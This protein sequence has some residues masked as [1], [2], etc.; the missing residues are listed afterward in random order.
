MA[1]IALKKVT[2]QYPQLNEKKSFFRRKMAGKHSNA[3]KGIDLEIEDGSFTVIVGPSG[4][5]KSTTLRMIAG[6]EDIT[7]GEIFIGDKKV[8]DVSSGD[9]NIAMVFQN[10][11][12]YPTM[13]VRQNIAFGLENIKMP[14]HEINKR[15]E[16]IS[17]TVGLNDYLDRKPGNLSGG[18]RQRVALARAIVKRPEV[19]IFDEPLS[20]LDAK[21]RAEMRSELIEM[22]KELKTTF[23]YVTHD[24]VEAM[25]MADQIVLMHEGEIMQ[26]G[27]PMELYHNPQNIFVAE[28]MGTPSMNVMKVNG[29]ANLTSFY[30]DDVSYV[31]F[32]PE[33]GI[34]VDKTE[35]ISSEI[36]IT[37]EIVTKEILGGETIYKIGN[38]YGKQQVKTPNA[39][40]SVGD[41]VK[42]CLMAEDI[43]YFDEG[44][45]RL[46]TEIKET[47]HLEKATI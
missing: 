3:V 27:S 40:F 25:S 28:F 14:K 38:V 7:E 15:V 35:E 34:L 45:N 42:L 16:T 6:L 33:K 23:I 32:R 36:Q 4:C 17:R 39:E 41:Q 20:N 26:A 8:N 9:R 10:Y 44:E 5:G 21:L 46:Y 22:H 12:L 29:Y 2:K 31:G 1:R 43:Y 30:M 19:Y 47:K 13:N 24:Q 37:S 18:Q 11:A